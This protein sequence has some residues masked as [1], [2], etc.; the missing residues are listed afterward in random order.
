LL[1]C[2]K[3]QCSCSFYLLNSTFILDRHIYLANYLLVEFIPA[4]QIYIF[5]KHFVLKL[6]VSARKK[7]FSPLLDSSASPRLLLLQQLTDTTA[8]R[9][10]YSSVFASITY[11]VFLKYELVLIFV[12]M[13][14][15]CWNMQAHV[16]RSRTQRSCT[17]S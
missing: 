12:Y 7:T 11:F 4:I 15:S 16:L 6:M 8:C 5:Q 9:Y 10:I 1:P 3:C 14:T 13:C 17:C 2:T